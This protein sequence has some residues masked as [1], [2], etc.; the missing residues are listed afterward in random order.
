L[1][2]G[3]VNQ[4]GFIEAVDLTQIENKSQLFSTGYIVTDITGDRIVE[5][6]D[7][8]LAENNGQLLLFVAKP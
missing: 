6:E 1:Y 3:D 8:S 4:D 7:Y 2:S 5:S